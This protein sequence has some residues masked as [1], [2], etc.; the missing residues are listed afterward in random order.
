MTIQRA[1]IKPVSLSFIRYTG[2]NENKQ[3]IREWLQGSLYSLESVTMTD[4]DNT[5]TMEVDVVRTGKGD[6]TSTYEALPV[7][8]YVMKGAM[9]FFLADPFFFEENYTVEPLY[10]HR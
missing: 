7:G 10:T 4:N 3:E 8:T 2:T 5:L 9:G 6:G 1:K